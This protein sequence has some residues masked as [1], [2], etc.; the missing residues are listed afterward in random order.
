MKQL[1]NVSYDNFYYSND[2]LTLDS[3]DYFIKSHIE[4]EKDGEFSAIFCLYDIKDYSH[5]KINKIDGSF[6]FTLELF[7]S[8]GDKMQISLIESTMFIKK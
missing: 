3:I 5:F 2:V 1:Y 4:L 8:D 7:F 6:D